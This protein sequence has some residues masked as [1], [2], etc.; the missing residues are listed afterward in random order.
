MKIISGGQTGADIAGLDAAIA[1]G[2]DYGGTLPKGRLTEEGPLDPKY[3]RM[4]E[5]ESSSYPKRTLKNVLDSDATLLFTVGKIS[6]GT[7]LTLRMAKENGKPYLHINL[8]SQP[9]DK[10]VQVISSWLSKVKPEILNIAGSRESKAPGIYEKV[11]NVL[12]KG[13]KG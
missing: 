9:E 8:E 2:I 5:L 13:I 7:A 6:G 3:D 4:T 12:I 11:F 1:L 10:A